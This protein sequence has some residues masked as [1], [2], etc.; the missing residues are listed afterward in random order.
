MFEFAKI[1]PKTLLV[2]FFSGHGVQPLD[3]VAYGPLKSYYNNACT[4]WMHANPG[5][6]MT[7]LNVAECF[8]K[9]YQLAFT[10]KNV[11]AGFKAAGIWPMNRDIFHDGVF[12]SAF[13]SIV[14]NHCQLKTVIRP[15]WHDQGRCYNKMVMRYRNDIYRPISGIPISDLYRFDIVE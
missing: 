2:P 14:H 10:P 1:I 7:I 3:V 4:G 5:T 8:G 11:Q 6:P 15:G 12:D 13:V 9:A